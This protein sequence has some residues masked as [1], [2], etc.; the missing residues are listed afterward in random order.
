MVGNVLEGFVGDTTVSC[1]SFAC[2]YIAS[3]SSLPAESMPICWR[4]PSTFPVCLAFS[5]AYKI[6]SHGVVAQAYGN[7]WRKS[8]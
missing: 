5:A 2:F 4:M 7:R 6:C 8:P 1:A 3:L